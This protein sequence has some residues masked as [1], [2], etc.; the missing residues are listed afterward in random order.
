MG[1]NEKLAAALGSTGSTGTTAGAAATRPA[2]QLFFATVAI[3]GEKVADIASPREAAYVEGDAVGRSFSATLAAGLAVLKDDVHRAG[4]FWTREEGA[5][6]ILT[7]PAGGIIL[8]WVVAYRSADR[9][10]TVTIHDLAAQ[11]ARSARK[12]RS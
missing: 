11:E 4:W 6:A 3:D 9:I 8:A 5:D 1:A 2:S 7:D 12:A 10:G